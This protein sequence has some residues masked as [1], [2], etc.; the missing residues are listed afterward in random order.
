MTAPGT[1]IASASFPVDA[2]I[3]RELFAEYAD[4]LGIDLSSQGFAGELAQLSGK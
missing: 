2:A 3:V 1:S 4:G